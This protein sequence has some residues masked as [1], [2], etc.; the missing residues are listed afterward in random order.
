VSLYW[1]PRAGRRRRWW[2]RFTDPW[3]ARWKVWRGRRQMR[4]WTRVGVT[5]DENREA[6]ISEGDVPLELVD[7][8][9]VEWP[10]DNE[11]QP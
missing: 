4:G 2:H 10:R 3:L 5:T 9:P 1:A 11:R 6:I 8:W 7:E